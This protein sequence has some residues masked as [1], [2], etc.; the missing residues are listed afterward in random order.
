MKVPRHIAII[1]DGNGRWAARHGLPRSIGHRKGAERVR[2][3]IGEAK[4]IGVKILTLFAF[5]TENW[6]RPKKEIER[7][8][9]Y[10]AYYLDREKDM[11]IKEDV[12]F[13]VF[14]RRDRLPKELLEK[15]ESLE[16]ST[17]KCTSFIF[18]LALDYGGRWDIVSASKKIARD[19]S[20]KKISLNDLDEDLFARYLCLGNLPDPD[21]FIRTSGELRI[22]NF[23]AWQLVYSEMYF[24]KVLW[25]SFD[26][27][28]FRKAINEYSRR[29][30]RFGTL[31]D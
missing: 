20:S 27:K 30:R 18:N 7:L 13:N 9:S 28:A 31:N 11:F 6:K 1:M 25:P 10:L 29:R 19:F 26:K 5:S 21:F 8:F 22:S 4:K 12:N 17:K 24:T 15:I 3:I 16:Y 14:G 23:L 2:G